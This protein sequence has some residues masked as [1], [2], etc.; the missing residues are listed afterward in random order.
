MSIKAP[1]EVLKEVWGYDT[2]RPLQRP[3]I[4]S[5][6]SGRDTLALLPTGGGKSIC[7]QVP[8]LCLPGLTIVVSPLIALMQD[9]VQQLEQRNVPA[10]A[11]HSGLSRKEIE[12]I[13][14]QCVD[15][16]VKLLYLSPERL[17]TDLFLG[18]L[19]YLQI[20]LLAV[21]EAH[22]I[23]QWGHE[24]RPS[25]RE[26]ADVRPYLKKCP[27]LAV[28]ATATPPVAEDIT[29]QLAMIDPQEFKGSFHRDNLKY[30]VIED[31]YEM[32]RLRHV[33]NGIK[34]SQIIYT[35]SRF[36]TAEIARHLKQRGI[37]ALFY[38]AGLS[39]RE[40][41]ER[42]RKWIQGEVQ[43]MVA[44]NAFGMGVDKADVRGV[45]HMDMPIS[46][47]AYYQEAGRGGRDGK[48]AFAVLIY[49]QQS[50][51][52]M[53]DRLNQMYPSLD[54]CKNVMRAI[55]KWSR[56]AVG[57][58]Q[59]ASLDFDLV[60]FSNNHDWKPISVFH[61]LRQ[62]ELSGW[63]QRS[64]GLAVP[65]RFRIKAS[66]EELYRLQLADKQFDV[67]IKTLLRSYE[68]VFIDYVR[69]RERDMAR[70]LE[71]SPEQVKAYLQRLHQKE[72]VEYL[73][74]KSGEQI[75]LLQ[76]RPPTGDIYIDHKAIRKN[77]KRAQRRWQAMKGYIGA[78]GCRTR[79]LLKYFGE[80][81]KEDCGACDICLGSQLKVFKDAEERDSIV[82]ALQEWL[83]NE[84]SISI[85]KWI[86][87]YPV[88]YKK[89]LLHLL[90]ELETSG[91]L[92]VNSSLEIEKSDG[93]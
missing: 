50:I 43:I 83:S 7:Y 65:S 40:R 17:K 87:K 81:L 85:R 8:A 67:F 2:F 36:R 92:R 9:Q 42:Q 77:K 14:Q 86:Y 34:G 5:V 4:D 10:K 59:Y 56:V 21:D 64:E 52:N 44:T 51:G 33:V 55:F 89:R 26:I 69:I 46:P 39:A 68:G 32:D 76:S 91:E 71:I 58:G 70:Q 19:P 6:L 15:G 45:I 61:A 28:T 82:A 53:E 57:A 54:F 60:K 78:E 73:P 35:Q 84:K 93:K 16:E 30:I 18:H 38:H 22:C 20:S 37:Q 75:T 31:S 74:A 11:L 13:L 25:Y 90:S 23:S 80:S 24:F 79:T 41:A 1:A 63:I 27:V 3:I 48:P 72:Y 66:R 49:D 12:Q 88:V 29:G 47:E 62:L